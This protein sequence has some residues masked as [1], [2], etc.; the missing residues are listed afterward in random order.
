VFF[1]TGGRFHTLLRYSRKKRRNNVEDYRGV[2]ILSA[3]PK[4]FELLVYREMYYDLQNLMSI[5]QHDFMKNRSTIMNLLE[6]ASFVLNS[7]EN[8]NQVDYFYTDF[9]NAIDLVRYQLLLD[10]TFVGIEPTR[11]M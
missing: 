3:I 10:E 9:S 4:R 7:I 5:N 11:C 1:P 8:S 2:A 6:Y